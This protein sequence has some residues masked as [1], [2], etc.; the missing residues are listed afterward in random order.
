MVMNGYR[1][2]G[3]KTINLQFL[4]LLKAKDHIM[5]GNPRFVVNPNFKFKYE[6]C[7]KMFNNDN[8]LLTGIN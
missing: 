4:I 5:L 6:S 2:D 7:V 1:K 3:T 8:N